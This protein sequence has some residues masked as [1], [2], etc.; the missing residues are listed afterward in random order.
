MHEL[1]TTET[2]V[3]ERAPALAARAPAARAAAAGP[4]AAPRAGVYGTSHKP[5]R[6]TAHSALSSVRQRTGVDGFML[7]DGTRL[8]PLTAHH[9]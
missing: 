8:T 3:S 5:N 1:N 9:H 4:G 6:R 7:S 2:C